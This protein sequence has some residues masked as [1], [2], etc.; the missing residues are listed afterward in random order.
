[1]YGAA[2]AFMWYDGV[3]WNIIPGSERYMAQY[4]ENGTTAYTCHRNLSLRYPLTDAET[5]N[6]D[7]AGVQ[8]VIAFAYGSTAPVP[9]PD[10]RVRVDRY[11]VS[12]IPIQAG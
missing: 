1:M 7:V 10:P 8:A 3:N 4:V 6:N 9:G 2:A 11:T 5:A 12:A